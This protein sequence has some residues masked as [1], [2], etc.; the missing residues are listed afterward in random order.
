MDTTRAK[1]QLGWEPRYTALAAL[2]DTVLG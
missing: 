2:H 1:T